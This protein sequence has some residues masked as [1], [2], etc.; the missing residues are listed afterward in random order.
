MNQAYKNNLGAISRTINGSMRPNLGASLLV[1]FLIVLG[2]Y[3][4]VLPRI[5][6]SPIVIQLIWGGIYGLILYGVYDF[7]NFAVLSVWPLSITLI[8]L[9][10]GIFVNAIFAVVFNYINNFFK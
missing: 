3:L 9:G 10:W 4:F 2:A 5:E 6:T 8:D 1:W 7:T